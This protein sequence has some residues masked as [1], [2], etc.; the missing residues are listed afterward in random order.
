MSY[1][2]KYIKYKNKYLELKSQIGG[3]RGIVPRVATNKL[4][5]PT[6]LPAPT[7]L[8]EPDPDSRR[9][10]NPPSCLIREKSAFYSIQN[11]GTCYIHTATR[12]VSRLLKIC[13]PFINIQEQCNEYYNTKICQNIFRCFLKIPD[14]CY[15]LERDDYYTDQLKENLSALLFYFIYL[16][17]F[18]VFVSCDSGGYD[19]NCISYIFNFIKY[20]TIN[21]DTIKKVF[22]YTDNNTK[23]KQYFNNLIE[24][25]SQYLNNVKQK[26][27]EGT[28]NPICYIKSI[29]T[30]LFK[31]YENF[32]ELKKIQ[33]YYKNDT[34]FIPS[35][36][37]IINPDLRPNKFDVIINNTQ[38]INYYPFIEKSPLE[39]LNQILKEGYYATLTIDTA[40]QKNPHVVVITDISN[41]DLVVKNTWL[42][43][44][45]TLAKE[46]KWCPL[47]KKKDKINFYEL[48]DDSFSLNIEHNLTY[49]IMFFYN[50][51]EYNLPCFIHTVTILV[52]QLLKLLYPIKFNG[53][54]QQCKF[55]YNLIPCNYEDINIFNYILDT[56]DC[57]DILDKIE[58]SFLALLFHFIFLKINETFKKG[59]YGNPVVA[60]LYILDYIKY[61]KISRK[62]ISIILK[63]DTALLN[64]GGKKYFGHFIN[65]LLV[66]LDNVQKR[67]NNT[68]NPTLYYLDKSDDKFKLQNP[69]YY[70]DASDNKF[71]PTS[72]NI[73]IPQLNLN[74]TNRDDIPTLQNNSML[75]TQISNRNDDIPIFSSFSSLDTLKII[76]RNGYY[77]FL[78]IKRPEKSVTESIIITD[79]DDQDNLVIKNPWEKDE[80]LNGAYKVF[81]PELINGCKI[82]FDDLKKNKYDYDINFFY[83]Q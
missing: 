70:F 61:A 25:L 50:V 3:Q 32:I 34:V 53:V 4:P 38:N 16:K 62:K 35:E 67:L 69:V 57:S 58:E 64:E 19:F 10:D 60:S 28:L 6:K 46:K 83:I 74:K 63:Y 42:G 44:D 41:N 37:N 59:E 22:N 8:I 39:I 43:N 72:D 17:L 14:S 33:L 30:N 15:S 20:A 76:L 27:K 80:C 11:G 2:E 7:P 29:A 45:T 51:P 36:T 81:F 1:K 12:L 47:I 23:Y 54:I 31:T 78:L 66:F 65:E 75:G 71:V 49:T 55:Y 73:E 77:A 13:V 18:Q 56:N 21:N 52:I 5:E 68:F 48:T 82:K 9:D 40:K 79:I 24:K 26:L